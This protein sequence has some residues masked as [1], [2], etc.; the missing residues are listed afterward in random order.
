MSLIKNPSEL[1]VKKCLSGLIYGQPGI[2]KSTLACSAPHAVLF[3]YDGGVGRINGAHQVP[4]LQ[5]KSWLD[6]QEALEEIKQMENVET[7]IIDTAGKMLAYMEEYAK[8]TNPK[9]KKPDG[10]LSLQ[11]Y[12][13][14]KQMFIQFIKDV[15]IMGKNVIFVAHEIEQKRGDD[16]IIR[17]EIGGS[18]ANDLV[19]ELD[20][21]G[22]MEASGK[23][24]TIS[25][26]PCEKF[27]AKNTCNLPGVI[28]IPV[29]VDETGT[30][31]GDNAFLGMVIENFKNRQT[32]TLEKT[33]EYELLIDLIKENAKEVVDADTAN[34][35]SEFIKGLT[36]IYNSKAIAG[37]LIQVKAKELG[38]TLNKTT[39]Q[40]GKAV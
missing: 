26:D 31:K 35:F 8:V 14:R 6:T 33:A 15:S 23:D 7:I 1:D 9:L 16:Y 32:Q 38:L 27:Y 10:T 11:G 22:Y 34:R 5:V 2:G 36:H 19:K 39:K 13:V 17:P 40:Y 18:S 12:G 28:K 20:L 25:F 21:V 29:V 3:D 24:R 30:A 37:C 4:T